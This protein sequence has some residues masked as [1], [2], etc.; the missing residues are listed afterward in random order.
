MM[1]LISEQISQISMLR[2][3]VRAP[4]GKVNSDANDAIVQADEETLGLAGKLNIES[5]FP[6]ETQ[7]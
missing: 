2:Q 1:G 5:V 7:E 3:Q 4:E 6:E